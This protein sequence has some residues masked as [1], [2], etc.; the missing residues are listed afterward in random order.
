MD[1]SI[2]IIGAGIAGLAAG[3]YGQM[4]GYP[5]RIFEKHDRPGGLCTSWKRKDYTIDGCLHWLVG[6]SPGNSFYR[7]WQE[8]GAVQGR[9]MIDHE[10]FQ[11]IEDEEGKAFTVYTDI[12]R[13]EQHMKELAPN[14][15]KVIEKFTNA[16]R[17]CA[18][19]DLP[20]DKAPELYGP[21]DMARLAARMLPY[22]KLQRTWKE[23]SIQDFAGEFTD[24]FLRRVFPLMFNLPDFPMMA[25]LFTLAWYSQKSAG[26]PEGGSLEF[27][28]AI[29]RRYRNLGG[30]LHYSS[31]VSKILVQGG[32]AVGVRLANGKEHKADIVISAADGHTTI[33][34]M[35]EGKYVDKKVREYY[36]K[37]PLFPPL[38]QVSLG[39][40]RSFEGEPRLLL[41]HLKQPVAIAGKEEKL[42][43]VEIY[44]FDPTLAPPGKTVIDVKFFADYDY[45]KELKQNPERYK[46]EK[47][48]IANQVIGLLDQRFPGLAVQVEMRD[49]ATPVTWERYTGNWRASFEGWLITTKNFG[50]SMSKTLPGLKNFYMCGQ[51]V[52]PGGGVPSAAMS[53]RN[54]IQVICKHDKKSFVANVPPGTS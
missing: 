15:K 9:R 29:E 11:T 40:A 33:F 36:E 7:I 53:A 30:E 28:R 34:Q 26:F 37:F 21:Q 54:L 27:S 31:P 38:I 14:D 45:W 49:V 42:L 51:W 35:L 12:D 19:I 32:K 46:K 6:S 25:A 43:G 44:N 5:T 47:E 41:Y 13:L 20:I 10:E 8:L 52:E 18:R 23:V 24:P 39:V 50:M 1:K 17:D 22:L 16:V 48:S 3:C 4:N 2:I